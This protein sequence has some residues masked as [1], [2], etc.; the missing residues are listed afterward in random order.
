M[1]GG[2]TTDWGA[3]MFD[4]AKWALDKDNSG[5]VEIV[6]PGYQDYDFLTFKYDNGVI[7]TGRPYIEQKT[8]CVTFWG[9]DGWIEV[10]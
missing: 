4:I 7:M 10:K 8:K 3:H 5:P 6:P 9:S 1:G 2:L